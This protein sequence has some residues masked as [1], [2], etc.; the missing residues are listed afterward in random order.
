MMKCIH[1]MDMR[2]K[3]QKKSIKMSKLFEEIRKEEERQKRADEENKKALAEKLA[4]EQRINEENRRIKE[5][6][7]KFDEE[8]K[9]K[10]EELIK[11]FYSQELDYRN[12]TSLNESKKN[13]EDIIGEEKNKG[14]LRFNFKDKFD[15]VYR[16]PTGAIFY[17]LCCICIL[18]QTSLN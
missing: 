9:K 13:Q 15:E 10:E 18:Q 11:K 8:Q 5:W 1:T 12:D 2:M 14:S 4:E 16:S 17:E 7:K 3:K 6:E